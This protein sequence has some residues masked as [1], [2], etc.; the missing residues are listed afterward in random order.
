MS[1]KVENPPTRPGPTSGR[2]RT[3]SPF[4]RRDVRYQNPA[5]LRT[6]HNNSVNAIARRQ[7]ASAAFVSFSRHLPI[8][9]AHDERISEPHS[10]ATSLP[11]PALDTM[12]AALA[13]GALALQ[14]Y[15]PAVVTQPT[16]RNAHTR[17]VAPELNLNRRVQSAA[18]GAALAASLTLGPANAADPW[19]YS[20]LLSKVNADEVAKVRTPPR[21]PSTP[22]Q[23]PGRCRFPRP[24]TQAH[25]KGNGRKRSLKRPL[26]RLGGGGGVGWC[27]GLAWGVTGRQ[28]ASPR[29]H[30]LPY[31]AF[32]A[33]SL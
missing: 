31:V 15:A 19:P 24:E 1:A 12:V 20:T 6:C 29:P 13:I 5:P 18:L 26:G 8:I 17:A 21:T 23:G 14:G 3:G 2:F 33:K 9:G 10:G 16:L 22:L 11:R 7:E 28:R 27:P 30:G 25:S 4:R 32:G